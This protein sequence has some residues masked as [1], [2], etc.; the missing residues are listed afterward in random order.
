LQIEDFF[1]CG[2]AHN[3]VFTASCPA[4]PSLQSSFFNLQSSMKKIAI[5]GSTGS[6]GRSALSI[7]SA[8]PERFSVVSLAAGNDA[9]AL[10]RQALRSTFAI[11]RLTAA[12]GLALLDE[13]WS[14]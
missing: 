5:L 7:I 8:Y 14:R 12:A 11:A 6:I 13:P 3:V 9:D 2:S 4:S 1:E 10:F